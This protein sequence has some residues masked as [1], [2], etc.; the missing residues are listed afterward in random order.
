MGWSYMDYKV[1]LSDYRF[2]KA[3]QCLNDA[4]SNLEIGS[5]ETAI[6]RAYYCVFNAIRS[7]FALEGIDYKKHSTVISFFRRDFIN[8]GI[9]ENE[10][11]DILG[12][13][14]RLR[15]DGD[16]IDFF[17]IPREE[18]VLQIDNAEYFLFQIK[19]YLEKQNG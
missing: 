3:V 11:S 16:Y 7:I 14:F 13:L 17:T 9:F 2:K 19:M 5:L 8:A 18:V 12:D 10:L 6:N 4:K 1:E 15:N